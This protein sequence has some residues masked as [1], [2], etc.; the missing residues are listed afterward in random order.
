MAG[1]ASS[2]AD[3]NTARQGIM[4]LGVLLGRYDSAIEAA[5][6]LLSSSAVGADVQAQ[7]QYTKAL[8]L[9]RQGNTAEAMRLW[10]AL[11]T[12][13]ESLYGAMRPRL[14][15]TGSSTPTRHTTTGWPA[16]SYC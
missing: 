5:D 14:R 8:A 6:G 15:S 9:S 3:I 4:N 2:A 11:A 13:P 10:S 7:A 16:D 12:D 1:K